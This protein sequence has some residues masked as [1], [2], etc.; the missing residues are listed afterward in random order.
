YE[1]A[2]DR[3]IPDGFLVVARLD[4]RGF[5]RLT[6]ERMDYEAPYDPRFRDAMLIAMSRLME[7]GFRVVFAYA[8]SD[9]I[10]LLFHPEDE[11]FERKHR[12]WL[13]ILSGEASAALSLAM[14]VHAVM[15]CRLSEM[16]DRKTVTDYF[17]WRME[18]A[19]R[20]CLNSHCYWM[21]RKQGREVNEA[22]DFLS[23]KSTAEKH[24][25]LHANGINF[26]GLP[27]WQKRGYG[28]RWQE[29]EKEG[30]NPI[31]GKTT[32]AIRRRVAADL[33]LPLGDEYAG[34]IVSL[35]DEGSRS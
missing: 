1:T 25:L 14:G 26:N 27:L 5:T 32:R 6:K 31:T 15:D 28:V 4:G 12:K 10:S 33:E 29:Y 13:S 19:S 3:T 34:M 30:H 11:S 22:T 35:L 16:P 23:G 24:D 8:Q 20:N 9:E 17:R 7:C 21:L 2:N 18:D